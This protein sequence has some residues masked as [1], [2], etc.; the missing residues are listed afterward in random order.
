MEK[1]NSYFVYHCPQCGKKINKDT[2][3]PQCGLKATC[4]LPPAICG[5]C[6][7]KWLNSANKYHKEIRRDIEKN[8]N[9]NEL[10]ENYGI[11]WLNGKNPYC[12]QCG[13][14]TIKYAR[15]YKHI[16][17]ISLNQ[18]FWKWL[19]DEFVFIFLFLA[20]LFIAVGDIWMLITNKIR[21][22]NDLIGCWLLLIFILFIWT[23]PFIRI[24]HGIKEHWKKNRKK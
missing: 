22:E 9:Y 10:N 4:E 8:Q 16:P 19:D 17:G 5:F 15:Q 3:C 7:D 23:I 20:G 11:V 24:V 21:N 13:Q 12:E 6:E 14:P 18:K 2:F 1:I